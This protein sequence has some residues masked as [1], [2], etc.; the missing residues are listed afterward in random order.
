MKKKILLSCLSLILF[1]TGC[2]TTNSPSTNPTSSPGA[3]ISSIFNKIPTELQEEVSSRIDN[4]RELFGFG[5]GSSDKL[6]A[7]A[8]QMKA[9]D[10]AKSDLN[11]K[12]KKE[13]QANLNSYC[14]SLDA[15]TKTLV[16]P[17][18]PELTTHA[19]E[20]I[21]YNI[22]QKGAWEDEK[23]VYALVTVDKSYVQ[24]NSRNVFSTFLDNMSEKISR[25]KKGM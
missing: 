12:V 22:S 20:L 8:G 10:N 16:K 1:I 11:K 24:S 23:K 19:T 3:F 9:L 7:A 5:S 18:I 17:A 2:V 15:Y 25:A 13:V 4:N 14:E 6:G 21:A